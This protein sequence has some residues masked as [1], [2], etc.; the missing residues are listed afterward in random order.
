MSV[1]YLVINV[2]IV[3]AGVLAAA[4]CRISG[5]SVY[6]ATQ[7]ILYIIVGLSL[8]LFAWRKSSER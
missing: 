8:V 1:R 5:G 7:V 6:K 4:I 2:A 3:L